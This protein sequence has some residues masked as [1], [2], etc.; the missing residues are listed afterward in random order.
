MHIPV[1]KHQISSAYVCI[2]ICIS[3]CICICIC[4][5]ILYLYG[6]MVCIYV[7]VDVDRDVDV[8][9]YVY[10]YMYIHMMYMYMHMLH[11]YN[12]IYPKTLRCAPCIHAIMALPVQDTSLLRSR[13][14][15]ETWPCWAASQNRAR[16][17]PSARVR[18]VTHFSQSKHCPT[19]NYQYCIQESFYVGDCIYDYKGGGS[20]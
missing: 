4:I 10:T 6:Y 7:Y 13:S 20:A 16:P 1:P 14:S 5:C 17:G 3:V 18:T 12:I 9:V 2:Y 8:C 19:P 15:V 11:I